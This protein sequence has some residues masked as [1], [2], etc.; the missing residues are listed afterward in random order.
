MCMCRLV[1]VANSARVSFMRSWE[2]VP[3][4]LFICATTVV[5]SMRNS[6]DLLTRRSGHALHTSLT[7][8]SS[9][10]FMCKFRSLWHQVP[11]NTL[12]CTSAPHPV[13]DASVWICTDGGG[14]RNSWPFS[15]KARCDHQRRSSLARSVSV[16]VAAG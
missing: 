8:R 7:A 10:T 2:R 15:V 13:L 12:P 3:P 1:T 16:I 11:W 9:S 4:C 14:G 5:L 6:T